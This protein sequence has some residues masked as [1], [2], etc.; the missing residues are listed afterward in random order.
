[1]TKPGVVNK[2]MPLVSPWFF[3]L[4]LIRFSG[5]LYGLN[6]ILWT[7]VFVLPLVPGYLSKLFFDALE[8]Q[9]PSW[10][11]FS[12]NV[13]TIIAVVLVLALVQIVNVFLAIMANIPW[14][15][16]SS[17]LLRLNVMRRILEMPGAQAIPGTVGVA[18]NT[19]R[20]DSDEAENASDWTL[21][22]FGRMV[23]LVMALALLIS[24][25]APLTA[26]VFLPLIGVTAISYQF[27]QSLE[28]LQ[29]K[30]R[31]TSSQY[32]GL[33]GEV[34]QSVQAIQVAG[35]ERSILAQLERRSAARSKAMLRN[36]ALDQ[37]LGVFAS[38]IV[39]LGTGLI[40]LLAGAKM[41]QREFTI[42][43]F[44]LFVLYLWEVG[45]H[46]EFFGNF[47]ATV[48][49]A[50]VAFQRMLELMRGSAQTGSAQGELAQEELA[51]EVAADETSMR[52]LR[53]ESLVQ[54]QTIDLKRDPPAL[55]APDRTADRLETLT[56][57]A[58]RFVHPS[59]G[60]GLEAASFEVHRGEFVVVTGR[61]GSGKTTLLRT[62]LGL[63]PAQSGS[64][65]WNA[66]AVPNPSEFMVPPHSAYTP[67]VPAL[68]SG[69][70]QENITLGLQ[71]DLPRAIY[72]AVL[73]QDLTQLPQGLETLVGVRGL[74]LSGG[75]L[76]RTA[77][78]RM[79]AQE[80]NL[81]VFDDIS[82]ALDV[83]TEREL[84][85]RLE[86]GTTCLVVSHRR[87]ALE[88][89]DRIVLLEHGRI[90]HSGSLEQ[91]L[92]VSAEMR[93][94]WSGDLEPDR[95]EI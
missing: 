34:Y 70:V 19:L 29:I 85:A 52:P 68:I 48:R 14:R 87:A 81:L 54:A 58:L 73:E 75:Q 69:S 79:F 59:S 40:L 72:R 51:Q 62:L 50:G 60:R 88:R 9:N 5:P 46:T 21:D 74:K 67:Q 77:A 84:W 8:Q 28:T 66:Q 83:N 65:H 38:N 53:A 26:F 43:E 47:M 64:V 41:R 92:S 71:T 37:A 55:V 23:Y 94:I 6:L 17:G 30:A 2:S 20:D 78:A 3:M 93:A 1:M 90:T 45:Y 11:G 76:Q 36:V 95:T 27:R 82:S 22:V 35:A 4:R 12:Y 7:G 13:K 31:E 32:T 16:R 63:L 18:L 86:P 89:A 15:F 80:A 56:V 24:I 44:S 42:G 33:L 10:N 61:I 39:S 49:R 91:L 57:Q 25:D